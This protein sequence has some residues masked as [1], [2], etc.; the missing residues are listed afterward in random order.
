MAWQLNRREMLKA[1]G[2]AAL[3]GSAGRAAGNAAP[4]WPF[5]AFDNG[6]LGVKGLQA[7]CKL[8]KDLGYAGLE[9]H[10]DH[11]ELPLMLEQLDKHGLK[12]F[13]IYTVPFMEDPLD[14]KLAGS[15]KLLK[16][17][18]T[19]LELGIRSKRFKPSDL[20]GNEA[21]VALVKR[22]SDLCGDSGPVVSIYPHVGFWTERVEDGV[23][24]AKLSGRANVGT[25]FNLVHWAWLKQPREMETVLREAL[26]HLFLL[27]LNGLKGPANTRQAIRPLDESDVDLLGFL[28]LLA[29]VGYTGPVGLQCYSIKE[30]AAEHLKRSMETWRAMLKQI[31]AA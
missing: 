7:K 19:R 28:K 4:H 3:G 24:M 8:L 11:R 20:A 27:T 12:M 2:L 9:Y 21:A 31:T 10:M 17:R 14:P 23:R 13:A 15:I 5:Y 16:G 6:L 30:P 29:K 1:L 18:D 25:N 26:P 22:V